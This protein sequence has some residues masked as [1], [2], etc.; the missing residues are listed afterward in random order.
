[1]RAF[2]SVAGC[3][4]ITPASVCKS[5]GVVCKIVRIAARRIALSHC[6][7][8]RHLSRGVELSHVEAEQIQLVVR[9][10]G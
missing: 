8:G 6:P 2:V 4:S 9:L 10:F 5:L 3:F 7:P 1:M